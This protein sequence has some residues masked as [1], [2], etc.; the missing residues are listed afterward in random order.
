MKRHLVIPVEIGESA[1]DASC[2]ECPFR[3]ID[4]EMG[5][6][7]GRELCMCPAWDVADVT[8]GERHVSCMEAEAEFQR[9]HGYHPSWLDEAHRLGRA[10]RELSEQLRTSRESNKDLIGKCDELVYQR[11]EACRAAKRHV[12]DESCD[13]CGATSGANPECDRCADSARYQAKRMRDKMLDDAEAEGIRLT[14]CLNCGC[15]ASLH[16]VDDEER[17][18]CMGCECAAYETGSA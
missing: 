16:V 6:P 1:G 7:R 12:P 14:R 3:T 8:G 17:R 11:D 5:E 10:V 15:V 13:Q 9:K 2:G 18:E 4:W